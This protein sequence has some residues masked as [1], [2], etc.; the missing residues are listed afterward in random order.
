MVYVSKTGLS[1][2]EGQTN[3]LGQVRQALG[4]KEDLLGEDAGEV[5]A[6]EMGKA[7]EEGGLVRAGSWSTQV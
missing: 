7:Q 2:A 6:P 1:P 5:G 3:P 4:F